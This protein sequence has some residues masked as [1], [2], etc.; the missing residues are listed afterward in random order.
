MIAEKFLG[1]ELE[2]AGHTVM[3]FRIRER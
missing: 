3:I 1:K 2:E